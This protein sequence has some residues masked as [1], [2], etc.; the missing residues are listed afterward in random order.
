MTRPRT[1]PTAVA[2][3]KLEA[4]YTQLAQ[5]HQAE[6]A[7]R[8]RMEIVVRQYLEGRA[9]ADELRAALRGEDGGSER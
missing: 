6:R 8:L 3:R 1:E 4:L 7:Q 5:W 2:Y 9:T